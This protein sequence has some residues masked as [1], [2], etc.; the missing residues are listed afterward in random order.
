M[1]NTSNVIASANE[2]SFFYTALFLARYTH[3]LCFFGICKSIQDLMK[4]CI[5]EGVL[6]SLL[7]T[8]FHLLPVQNGGMTSD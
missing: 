6:L 5:Q 3:R 2:M 8:T 1:C 4:F 7:D